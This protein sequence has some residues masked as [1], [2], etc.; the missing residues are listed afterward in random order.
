MFDVVGRI[1]ELCKGRGWTYYELSNRA[2]LSVNAMYNWRS[3]GSVP[4][5]P[6]I[7]KICEAMDITIAEFFMG[8][9]NS[10]LATDEK[11]ILNAWINLSD[12][13]KQT[14]FHIINTFNE[15]KNR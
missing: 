12:S 13:E 10:D 3:K 6:I 14:I 4:T 7:E 1:D 5:L 9:D 11:D 15:I 8:V 2:G